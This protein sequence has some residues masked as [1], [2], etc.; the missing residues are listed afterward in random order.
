MP[1]LL[2]LHELQSGPCVMDVFCGSYAAVLPS[3]MILLT[4]KGTS[5]CLELSLLRAQAR[6]QDIVP[7]APDSP[8]QVLHQIAHLATRHRSAAQLLVLV[9]CPSI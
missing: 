6:L 2:A 5:S 1:G 3:C 9:R 4:A 8:S 7:Q